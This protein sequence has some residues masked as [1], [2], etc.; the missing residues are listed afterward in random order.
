MVTTNL[1]FSRWGE[2]FGEPGM[3]AALLDRLT[4]R[5]HIIATAGERY[6]LRH[7]RIQGKGPTEPEPV[8]R[9]TPFGETN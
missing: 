9:T 7:A 4:Y 5:A 2:V 8:V 3:T 1:E 6:R